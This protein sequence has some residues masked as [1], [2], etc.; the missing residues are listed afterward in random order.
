M[1]GHPAR[2]YKMKHEWINTDADTDVVVI[3]GGLA[4]LTAALTLGRAGKQVVLLEKAAALGGRAASQQ[5]GDYTFNLGPHA[6][7]RSGAAFQFF[8]EIGL[9]LAGGLPNQQ[10][11]LALSNGERY[12]LPASPASF[13]KTR[14]LSAGEK[15]RVGKAL[16]RLLRDQPEA[17]AGTTISDYLDLLGLTGRSRALVETLSRISTYGHAPNK[18]SADILLYQYQNFSNGNVLYLDSGWQSL[19]DGLVDQLAALP[20]TIRLRQRVNGISETAAGIQLALADGHW[21]RAGAA[22][23]AVEPEIAAALLPDVPLATAGEPVAAACLDVALRRLPDESFSFAAGLDKPYYYSV[24]STAADLAPAGHALIHIAKYLAPTGSDATAT[25][26]ELMAL[27]DQLQPGWR[28]ELSHKR[29]LPHLRV[30]SQLATAA[31]GGLAGRQPVTIAGHDRLFL[32][33]DWV[34]PDGWLVDASVASARAAARSAE[35]LA[36]PSGWATRRVSQ[37]VRS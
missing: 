2:G 28:A 5:K 27:L 25:D 36:H 10:G 24:H 13:L 29:F 14:L 17:Y 20:V 11:A 18:M 12:L 21:L 34:G 9:P 22:I 6:L 1:I 8:H 37:P 32:A 19:V 30:V 31:G 26:A 16:L 15:L 23:L 4:G 33:G 35:G 7:Y 3:G